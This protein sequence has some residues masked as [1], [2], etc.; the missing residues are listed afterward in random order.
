MVSSILTHVGGRIRLYRKNIGMSMEE[1]ALQI[2]KSKASVS[3]YESGLIAIDV[4]TLCRIAKALHVAPY[5]LLDYTQPS[6]AEPRPAKGQNPLAQAERLYLYHMDRH[7][8]HLSTLKLDAGETPACAT[9][10]YKLADPKAPSLSEP[11]DCIYHGHMFSHDMVLCFVLRNHYNPVENILLNFV[12]PMR[13]ADLLIG[14]IS[15]LTVAPLAPTAHKML[16]STEPVAMDEK[17][18]ALLTID[19]ETFREMKRGNKLFV[20]TQ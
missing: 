17:L 12:I 16:L 15:G 10:F 2:H 19:A 9:L 20:P 8:M 3:K 18:R 7:T 4:E 6:P 1:L 13:K 14:M 5:H 11:C